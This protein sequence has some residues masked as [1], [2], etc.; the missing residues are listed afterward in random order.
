MC[1]IYNKD[2]KL[3]QGKKGN[4]NTTIAGTWSFLAL[5]GPAHHGVSLI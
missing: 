1:Y 4:N 2:L 3:S 5:Q